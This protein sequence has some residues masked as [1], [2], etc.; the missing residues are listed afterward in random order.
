MWETEREDD[1]IVVASCL[2]RGTALYVLYQFEEVGTNL[3]LFINPIRPL[4]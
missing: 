4:R 1:E 3:V 2:E